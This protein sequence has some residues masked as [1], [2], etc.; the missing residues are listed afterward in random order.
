MGWDDMVFT[1]KPREEP[2]VMEEAP[3]SGTMALAVLGEVPVSMG[4]VI[5]GGGKEKPDYADS[6]FQ[7]SQLAEISVPMP[8]KLVGSMSRGIALKPGESGTV[9]FVLA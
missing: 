9:T 3:D 2:Y 5:I 1:D 6:V 8:K 4:S 7:I